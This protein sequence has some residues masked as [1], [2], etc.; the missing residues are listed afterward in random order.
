MEEYGFRI[1]VVAPS[2]ARFIKQFLDAYGSFPF[3]IVGDPKRKAYS[4]LGHQTMPKAK[5]LLA[6]G[7]G[8]ITGKVKNFI[9]KEK[10]KKNVVMKSM[11]NADVYI[12]GGTWIFNEKGDLLWKHIDKSPDDHAKIDDILRQLN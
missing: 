12:Q 11:K 2:N 3:E 9:P 1:I 4:G 5:L 10:S 7:L 8:V 6:A